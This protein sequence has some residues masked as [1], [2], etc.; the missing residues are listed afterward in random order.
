MLVAGGGRLDGGVTAAPV[1]GTA[2]RSLGGAGW[3]PRILE[4]R[5]GWKGKLPGDTRG[6]GNPPPRVSVLQASRCPT[7]FSSHTASPRTRQTPVRSLQ[8]PREKLDAGLCSAAE[9]RDHEPDLAGEA[10]SPAAEVPRA[11]GV[12]RTH[13][14]VL[15]AGVTAWIVP[16]PP[17]PPLAPRE[18][19]GPLGGRAGLSQPPSPQ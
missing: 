8:V 14:P 4:G 5:A 18:P 12:E 3:C 9:T 10:Q 1:L 13:P 6:T 15:G 11:P 19:T 17:G 16:A 2:P 7:A